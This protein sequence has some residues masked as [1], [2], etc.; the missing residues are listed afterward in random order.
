MDGVTLVEV[1]PVEGPPCCDVEAMDEG[2]TSTSA[3]AGAPA[4]LVAS[5]AAR[6]SFFASLALALAAD[7][8][9]GPAGGLRDLMGLGGA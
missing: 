8:S 1:P 4:A 9:D 3:V 7:A 2:S 5:A 6:F